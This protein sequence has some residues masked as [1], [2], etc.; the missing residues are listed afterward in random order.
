MGTALMSEGAGAISKVYNS[1]RGELKSNMR[2]QLKV[3]MQEVGR[4]EIDFEGKDQKV[5]IVAKLLEARPSDF[6]I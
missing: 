1:L 6:G 5:A 3:L 2:K 4:D